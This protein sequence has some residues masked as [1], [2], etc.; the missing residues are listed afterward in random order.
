[1]VRLSSVSSGV[2]DQLQTDDSG[3]CDVLTELLTFQ[4]SEMG[5]LWLLT[6]MD[7]LITDWLVGE[8]SRWCPNMRV[9]YIGLTMTMVESVV[10]SRRMLLVFTALHATCLPVS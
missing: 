4:E 7:M 10:A 6:S 5:M 2:V 1:M 3:T 9:S 8:A